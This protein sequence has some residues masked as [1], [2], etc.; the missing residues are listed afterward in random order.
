MRRR[1]HTCVL[2]LPGAAGRHLGTQRGIATRVAHAHT[3]LPL[4]HPTPAS[5][6]L[7]CP[8]FLLPSTAPTR[9]HASPQA[10]WRGAK[11]SWPAARTSER[12]KGKESA[13]AGKKTHGNKTNDGG[14]AKSVESS[15]TRRFVPPTHVRVHVLACRSAS[16]GYVPSGHLLAGSALHTLRR[17]SAHPTT[18]K[19]ARE[20]TWP[21]LTPPPPLS[22]QM[23]TRICARGNAHVGPRI[24]LLCTCVRARRG[25]TL[26]Q[27]SRTGKRAGAEATRRATG[28]HRAA[29]G[30]PLGLRSAANRKQMAPPGPSPRSPAHTC[31]HT[32]APPAAPHHRAVA[33]AHAR[34]R[35]A[36][37]P[38]VSPA[39]AAVV[40]RCAMSFHRWRRLTSREKGPWL[41]RGSVRY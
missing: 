27:A 11:A 9:Q 23:R 10:P 20:S 19:P 30:H 22:A 28:G 21:P 29:H 6:P 4:T 17:G 26:S 36:R 33:V 7:S 34:H 8:L 24:A 15:A 38:C 1:I 3:S 37:F 25:K 39:P 16:Q 32:A 12:R 2:A 40:L 14:S 31:W 35:Y 5:L 18:H 41:W 13:R